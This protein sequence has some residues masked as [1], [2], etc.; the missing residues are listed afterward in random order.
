MNRSCFALAQSLRSSVLLFAF[1]SSHAPGLDF[2]LTAA[3]S[4]WFLLIHFN[5]AR[6]AAA[7]CACL[8]LIRSLCWKLFFFHKKHPSF[9]TKATLMGYNDKND[10]S[11]GVFHWMRLKSRNRV[12]LL[13]RKT[14]RRSIGSVI[15]GSRSAFLIVSPGY[16]HPQSWRSKGRQWQL[17]TR[18]WPFI[19]F[20]VVKTVLGLSIHLTLGGAGST[21]GY[22]YT[23]LECGFF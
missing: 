23:G 2:P 19:N 6:V 14:R 13:L 10:R 20:V 22:A 11:G 7:L 17:S 1:L 18:R 9:L 3:R 12:I 21:C 15:F 8:C 4:L 16:L 5:R